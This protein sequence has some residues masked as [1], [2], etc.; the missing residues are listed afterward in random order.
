MDLKASQ[1]IYHQLECQIQEAQKLNKPFDSFVKQQI[2][3][4]E[5][6]HDDFVSSTSSANNTR[7]SIIDNASIQI[8]QLQVIASLCKKI[9]L[10]TEKYDNKIR[11]IRIRDLGADFVKEHEGKL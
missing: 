1:K 5:E 8:K 6:V 9:G 4:L 3:I 11:E 7:Q 2:K 10:S